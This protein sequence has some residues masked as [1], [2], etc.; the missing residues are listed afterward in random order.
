METLKI[1]LKS[2]RVNAG[3]SIKEAA[4]NIGISENT[5]KNWESGKTSPTVENARK[6]CNLYKID[7]NNIAF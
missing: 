7:Y 3:F 5:L 4:K 2:C 6:I 1:S